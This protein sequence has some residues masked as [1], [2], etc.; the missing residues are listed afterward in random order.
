[1]NR[2]HKLLIVILLCFL[3]VAIVCCLDPIPQNPSYHLFADAR[4]LAGMSF[5]FNVTSNLPFLLIGFWG[6]RLCLRK[7]GVVFSSPSASRAWLSLFAGVFAVGLGSAWYHLAPDNERLV[8]DRLPMTLVFM[9]FCAMLVSERVSPAGGTVMLILLNGIGIFSVWYWHITDHG[10]GGD[11]RPYV[12]VQ[13]APMVILPVL[14]LLFREGPPLFPSLF[15]LFVWYVLAKVLEHYDIAVYRFTGFVSGHTLKHLAAS[16]AVY[17][18]LAI[19]LAR[20]KMN[21][22]IPSPIHENSF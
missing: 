14:L 12:L 8:W 9:S 19:L 7:E 22:T 1:M 18:M 21:E 6:L 16:A 20:R 11:L 5:F 17:C 2:L 15:W 3:A 10:G 13:F 4:T